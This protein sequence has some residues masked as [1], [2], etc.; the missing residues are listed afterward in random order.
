M[1]FTYGFAVICLGL[2]GVSGCDDTCC[3]CTGRYH[4]MPPPG[5]SLSGT[6]EFSVWLEGKDSCL[7]ACE[8]KAQLQNMVAFTGEETDGSACD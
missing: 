6:H 2:V 5:H 7:K 8:H 1:K 4:P 3:H